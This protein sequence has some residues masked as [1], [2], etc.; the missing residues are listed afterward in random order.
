MKPHRISA[1]RGQKSA[2]ESRYNTKI[3]KKNRR[4]IAFQLRLSFRWSAIN[5]QFFTEFKDMGCSCICSYFFFLLFSI[6]IF[7]FLQLHLKEPIIS[8][9][10]SLLIYTQI[11]INQNLLI[12]EKTLWFQKFPDAAG[13]LI[14]WHL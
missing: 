8:S 14:G 13:R 1:N 11:F 7:S 10:F 4:F 5:H 9:L 12:F 2:I 3:V 6:K